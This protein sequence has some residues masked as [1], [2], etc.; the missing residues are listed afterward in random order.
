[1]VQFVDQQPLALL[2]RLA[3]LDILGRSIPEQDPAFAVATRK[4][5]RPRPAVAA[6]HLPH[7]MLD[8]IG[9]AGR[10]AV[11]PGMEGMRPVLG[12]DAFAPAVAEPGPARPV[13]P[14]R[15][16]PVELAVG[17]RGPGHLR[18]ELDGMA[19]MV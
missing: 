10:D 1:M 14:A 2:S 15:G 13:L 11:G 8:V 9:L 16:D 3:L 7:P 19:V 18:V 12:M 5:A 6:V 4:G 17:K